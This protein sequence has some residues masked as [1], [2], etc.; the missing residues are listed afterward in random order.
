MYMI[1]VKMTI[2]RRI[3]YDGLLRVSFFTEIF[4]LPHLRKDGD[5]C[6]EYKDWP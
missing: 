3:G 4:A 6:E 5:F 1:I 2:S